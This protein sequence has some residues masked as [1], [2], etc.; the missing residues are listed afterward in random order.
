MMNEENKAAYALEYR[1]REAAS[2]SLIVPT[3]SDL[4]T[5]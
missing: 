3:H 4:F 5:I 1:S 2:P